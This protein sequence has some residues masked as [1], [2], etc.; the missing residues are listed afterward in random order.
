MAHA[1]RT[2]F[3]RDTV[4]ATVALAALYALARGVQFQPVQIPGYLLVVG[5]DVVEH[6]IGPVDAA[7]PAL[8]AVY[9]VALG[10]VGA[11]AVHAVRTRVPDVAV[12]GW[13][14]GLAG[15]LGVVGV[16]SLLF[17]VAILLGTSQWEPVAVTGVA[18]VL[19]LGV[20]AWLAG[21]FGARP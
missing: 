9:L 7:F 16:L 21:L 15:A 3:L 5:F 8:F 1:H 20:A 6:A 14:P 18:G 17:A 4:V 11:T 19:L 12:P 2:P 13:R 10:L